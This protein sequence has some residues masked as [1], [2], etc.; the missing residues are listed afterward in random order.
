MCSIIS[1]VI[2]SNKMKKTGLY[3]VDA[4]LVIAVIY[5]FFIK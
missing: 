5:I 4:L 2:M 1:E 3:I